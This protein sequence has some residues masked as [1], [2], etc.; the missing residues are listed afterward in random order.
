MPSC[1]AASSQ[2]DWDSIIPIESRKV[3]L[4]SFDSVFTSTIPF[5]SSKFDKLYSA[6]IVDDDD[7]N[8]NY[9]SS[10]ND[11]NNYQKSLIPRPFKD[12][13]P[14]TDF[15]I[16]RTATIVIKRKR[17]KLTHYRQVYR[18]RRSIKGIFLL[19]GMN[20]NKNF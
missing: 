5:Y 4:D 19:R 20:R 8:N 3:I 14:I 6:V 18:K 13:R 1:T 11:N 2:T 7:K 12:I 10:N 17:V 9:N 16:N 15:I